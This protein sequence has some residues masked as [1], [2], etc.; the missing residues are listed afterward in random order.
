[1]QRFERRNFFRQQPETTAERAS[2]V[3]HVR[4]EAADAVAAGGAFLVAG[5]GGLCSGVGGG[6]AR[7]LRRPRLQRLEPRDGD[8]RD[9]G[10]R[11]EAKHA[12]EMKRRVQR[13][14]M[15]YGVPV[16]FATWSVLA[17]WISHITG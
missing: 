1:M 17:W 13:R 7:R 3:M 8:R 11:G 9:R 16:A 6:G 15:P 14:L 2:L 5:V 4:A 12:A 10:L